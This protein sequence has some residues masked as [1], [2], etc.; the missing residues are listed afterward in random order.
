MKFDSVTGVVTCLVF[1]LCL[2][3]C[4]RRDIAQDAPVDRAS[5]EAE[6]RSLLA[7]NFAAGTA[8]DPAGVQ[9][10]YMPDGDAWIAGLS[11]VSTGEELLSAEEEFESLPGFQSFDGTIES[12]R[13][14]S[15][16]AAIAAAVVG[17]SD[18]DRS[19]ERGDRL[20]TIFH[21]TLPSP[22]HTRSARPFVPQ[23]PLTQ[24]PFQGRRSD[25]Q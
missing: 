2:S 13:F 21:E 15:R 7:A 6:I 8:L 11:R 25:F 23:F 18:R 4:N 12:I 3:G 17:S 20:G 19:H 24:M 1:S 16:D 9:D 22:A 14:I 10:T 5:D